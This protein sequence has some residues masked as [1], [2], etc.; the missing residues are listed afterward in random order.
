MN[1]QGEEENIENTTVKKSSI[2]TTLR[3]TLLIFAGFII[4]MVM[5]KNAHEDNR[6]LMDE[7]DNE[8]S[9]EENNS[10]EEELLMDGLTNSLKSIKTFNPNKYD[11][12]VIIGFFENWGS[13]IR[14]AEVNK[15]DTINKMGI[16][17]REFVIKIQKDELPMLRYLYSKDMNEKLWE[18]NI[19]VKDYGKNS[20]TLEFIGGFFAS[21]MNKKDFQNEIRDIVYKLRFKQV[22]YKW[23][24]HDDEYT[25][26]TMNTKEDEELY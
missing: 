13:L 11:K 6:K 25:Y 10:S 14:D 24:E 26:Y 5:A 4:L 12:E 7:M 21:N 16:Q 3:W 1:N 2:K 8:Y 18:N 17:L 15:I 9:S 20:T 23:I 22:N 19:K